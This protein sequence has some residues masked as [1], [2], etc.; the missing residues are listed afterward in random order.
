MRWFT[1]LLGDDL[2]MAMGLLWLGM[3]M[4]NGI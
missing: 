1:W 3:R 4:A 2:A